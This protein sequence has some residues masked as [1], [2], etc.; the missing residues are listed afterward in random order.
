MRGGI[1]SVWTWT[2]PDPDGQ[3][4]SDRQSHT[5]V[6]KSP[7][8]ELC[9]SQPCRPGN[10]TGPVSTI[11][12]SKTVFRSTNDRPYSPLTGSRSRG[13]V[14]DCSRSGALR[15]SRQQIGIRHRPRPR[16]TAPNLRRRP[17]PPQ[18]PH[19]RQYRPVG[20]A[21]LPALQPPHLVYGHRVD[22][23]KYTPTRARSNSTRLMFIRTMMLRASD[24]THRQSALQPKR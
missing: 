19:R 16:S 4:R 3:G 9:A 5:D 21:C 2:L 15:L 10:G 8:D 23:T 13:Q 7:A 12:S 18:R 1:P 20:E 22:A 11:R 6:Q 17:L 14:A 24:K